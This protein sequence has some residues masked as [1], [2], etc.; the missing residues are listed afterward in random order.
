MPWPAVTHLTVCVSAGHERESCK[1]AEPIEMQS[2]TWTR[3]AEGTVN[4]AGTGI[5]HGKGHFCGW[6]V[7]QDLRAVDIIN[8]IPKWQH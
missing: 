4:Y 2:G 3:G 1:T 7:G 5:P 6:Y 8:I